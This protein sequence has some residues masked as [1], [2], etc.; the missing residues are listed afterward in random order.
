MRDNPAHRSLP[1]VRRAMER[2]GYDLS[3]IEIDGP[4]KGR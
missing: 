1:A 3:L 2:A 4:A